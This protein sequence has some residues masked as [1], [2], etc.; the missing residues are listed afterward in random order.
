MHALFLIVA[1]AVCSAFAGCAKTTAP[2]PPAADTAPVRESIRAAGDSTTA[3]RASVDRTG[4]AI[5]DARNATHRTGELLD[6]NERKAQVILRWL[7][8][9]QRKQFQP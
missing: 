1:L 7:N 5:A 6:A 2:R 8:S 4:A 9:K 3:A